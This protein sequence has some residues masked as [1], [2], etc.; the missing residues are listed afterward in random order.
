[1]LTVISEG[2]HVLKEEGLVMFLK[3]ASSYLLRRFLDLSGFGYVLAP[4]VS[5]KLKRLAKKTSDIQDAVALAFSFNY[6]GVSIKPSQIE[7]E[8]AKL[9]EIIRKTKPKVILEIGTAKG[10]T[11]FL[12][13]QIA[14]PDAIVISIDLP[15]GRFGGG[16]P[17]WMTPIFKSFFKENQELYL[18]RRDSHD[19]LTLNIVKSILAD[20]LV[21]F[22][23]IDGDHTYEG[24]KKDFEMYSPLVRRGGII[25]F[26]DI[27]PHDRVHDPHGAVG[28]PRFW[29]E[30]KHSYK[31]LEIVKDWNQGWAGIGVLYV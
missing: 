23:F 20:R 4:F 27:V 17:K 21:D 16:H 25:A 9:L 13:A 31:Y 3:K 19:P 18:I 7:Y 6:L 28:V 14:G 30:I 22:L 24:V 5:H 29:N 15:G 8:I 26:H 1:M 11:L 10:G 12:F 2:I